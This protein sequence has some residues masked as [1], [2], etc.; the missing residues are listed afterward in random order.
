MTIDDETTRQV[1]LP[2]WE[3]LRSRAAV[4]AVNALPRSMRTALKRTLYHLRQSTFKPYITEKNL[5]GEKFDFWIGDTD[6]R[7]WYDRDSRLSLEL[8]FIRNHM[9]ASGD[10]VLD[11]G[12]HHGRAA[13]L[14]SRWVGDTGNVIAFEPL[15]K[16]GDILAK[17]IAL[18]AITN[19][20]LVRKAVGA[21]GGRLRIDGVS[22][23]TVIYSK[24]GIEVEVTCLDNYAHLNPAF[25]K[26]DVEGF[27]YQVLQGAR[28]V[29]SRRPKL[30][31]EIHGDKLAKYGASFEQI[32]DVI[33]LDRYKLWIQWHDDQEPEEYDNKTPIV[34]RVHL[35]GV[36][37]GNR[38]S[39]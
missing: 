19:V 37:L 30:A 32:L 24:Q 31:I 12:A 5:D 8:K 16:N 7:D 15:P 1:T 23:S 3:R 4:A 39:D 35:F 6:G 26:V 33:G 10:L 20:T 25:V 2:T 27:E 11:C 13:I 22:D 34:R 14:F 9:I 38:T 28:H 21:N 36:P 29:L 18:N 17:N